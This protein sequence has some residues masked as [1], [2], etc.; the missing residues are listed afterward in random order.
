MRT[1]KPFMIGDWKVEPDLDRIVR[2][3]ERRAVRPQV[4]SL[5]V[6]LAAQ[7]GSVAKSEKLLRDLWP[8]KIVTDA[9]LYNCIAELRRLLDDGSGNRRYVETIHKKG[10]RLREPVTRTTVGAG[11]VD[12]HLMQYHRRNHEG[13]GPFVKAAQIPSEI[14]LVGNITHG[15]VGRCGRWLVVEGE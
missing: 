10:Y 11:K 8:N 15:L 2:G 13:G 4:M 12:S 3:T 1:N 7:G 6:Y 5:L 9:T 14:R